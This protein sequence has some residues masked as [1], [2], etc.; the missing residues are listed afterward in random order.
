MSTNEMI[1]ERLLPF[2]DIEELQRRN[3][4][5][6][7]ALRELSKQSE[8]AELAKESGLVSLCD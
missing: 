2:H 3:S 6:L 1:T 5:L 8:E 7:A 4:E